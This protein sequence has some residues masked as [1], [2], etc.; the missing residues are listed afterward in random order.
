MPRLQRLEW[1]YTPSPIYFITAC[2]AGRRAVLAT[3]KVHDAFRRFAGSAPSHGV[4][5]GRYVLM[6]DHFHLFAGFSDRGPDLSSWVRSLK[7]F[8]SATLRRNNV[9]ST[10]WQK[11]F[12]DH[13][14]RSEESYKQKWEYVRENPVRAG[15]V[16]RAADWPYQG[17]VHSLSLGKR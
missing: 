2:I 1:V 7:G 13:V 4:W 11:G 14:L 17:E 10:H 6:P 8:L 15:L 9:P 12:F 5:M 3:T 16:E